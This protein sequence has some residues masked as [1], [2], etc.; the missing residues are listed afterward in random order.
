MISLDREGRVWQAHGRL[1]PW[2]GG[3]AVVLGYRGDERGPN[4]VA[5]RGIAGA[6]RPEIERVGKFPQGFIGI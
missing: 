6:Q 1:G 2:A 5:W 4:T 3:R